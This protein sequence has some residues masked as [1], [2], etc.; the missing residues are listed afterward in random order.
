MAAYL[1]PAAAE[2]RLWSREKID[3]TL[4]VGDVEA[5]SAE[6]DASGPFIGTKKVLDGTQERAFPRSV[7]PDGMENAASTPPDAVLDAVALLAYH[8][9]SGEGPAVTS[10]SMDGV[11]VTYANPAEPVALS[12]ARTLLQPWLLKVGRRAGSRRHMAEWERDFL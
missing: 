12:R 2:A 7:R 4:T 6:V 11:S 8:S 3:A 10:E 1:T 9:A 5:A